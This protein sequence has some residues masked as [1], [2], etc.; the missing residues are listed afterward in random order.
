MRTVNIVFKSLYACAH[1]CGFC[2]VLHVPRNISYMSTSQVKDTFDRIE[3]MFEG[4]RVEMEVSGGEFTLRKD[5]VEL[6][7]YLRTKKIRWSSLVLDTMAVP[8]ADAS[9]AAALGALFDKANVSIH[10]CDTQLHAAISASRTSFGDLATALRNIFLYFPAVFTNTSINKFNVA[11]LHEVAGFILQAREVSPNTPLYCLFYIPVYRRYGEAKLENRFRLAGEDN[12]ELIPDSQ[13]LGKLA[14]EF[15]RLRNVLAAQNVSALLRD[16]NVP[17]CIY[18]GVTKTFPESSFALPN[19]TSDCY[20]IDYAH[21][22][23]EHHTL[24]AVY[25]SL[26]DRAKPHECYGC[27]ADGV[28][29][30]IPRQWLEKGYRAHPI[31]ETEY[32]RSFALQILNHTVFGL[33]HDA[34]RAR[35]TLA[36]LPLD[37]TAIAQGFFRCLGGDPADITAARN[38]ISVLSAGVRADRLIAHLREMND[39]VARVLS[40]ILW[41]ERESSSRENVGL[42]V[43]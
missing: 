6:I 2:H 28:C 19:F 34:V 14:E 40:G 29:A 11:R 32:A 38:R 7:E 4:Q 33:F 5:A 39:P 8:L 21:P 37:W 15:A 35:A 16:F 42:S 30:G 24:E 27:V 10:A 41:K 36:P 9:L 3:T 25:P 43:L 13:A 1:Q 17:A 22:L 26:E 31:D 20:F 23:H 18:H 12:A